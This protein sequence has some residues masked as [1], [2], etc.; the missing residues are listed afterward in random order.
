M[1][2][3]RLGNIFCLI[4]PFSEC[5]TFDQSKLKFANTEIQGTVELD[6]YIKVNILNSDMLFNDEV[7]L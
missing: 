1:N 7:K 5:Y 4:I 2:F 3:Q 6:L